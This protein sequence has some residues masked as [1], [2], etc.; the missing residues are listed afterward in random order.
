[1]SLVTSEVIHSILGIGIAAERFVCFGPR[2]ELR[3]R[4][5]QKDYDNLFWINIKKI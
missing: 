4:L 5:H 3:F 2:N 1:M